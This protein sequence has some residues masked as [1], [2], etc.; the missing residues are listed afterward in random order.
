M[1]L[2]CRRGCHRGPGHLGAQGAPSSREPPPGR[3]GSA[4]GAAHGCSGMAQRSAIHLGRPQRVAAEMEPKQPV[5]ESDLVLELGFLDG[6][7]ARVAQIALAATTPGLDRLVPWQV[8]RDELAQD[9]IGETGTFV[10]VVAPA[11]RKEHRFPHHR[12]PDARSANQ[13][14]RGA[15]PWTPACLQGRRK[16]TQNRLHGPGRASATIPRDDVDCIT[17]ARRR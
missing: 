13:R 8:V 2:G 15:G 5:P 1:Q 11:D 9:A 12:G 7:T 4:P 10:H 6:L 17:E 16:L 3:H 14:G